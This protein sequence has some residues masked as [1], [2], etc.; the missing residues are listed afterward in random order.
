M[1]QTDRATAQDRSSPDF[2]VTDFYCDDPFGG[3]VGWLGFTD[4]AGTDVARPQAE[5]DPANDSEPWDT[6]DR[7]AA[8]TTGDLRSSEADSDDPWAGYGGINGGVPGFHP[9]IL[10]MVC[11]DGAKRNTSGGLAGD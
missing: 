4:G 2:A 7:V 10:R 8:G 11:A 1:G 9:G 5:A 6:T 3:G